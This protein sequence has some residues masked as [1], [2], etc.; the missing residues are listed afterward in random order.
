MA[1]TALV[2]MTMPRL[3]QRRAAF[4]D[5]EGRRAMRSAVSGLIV[6]CNPILL[7]LAASAA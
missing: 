1:M 6:R 5:N 3:L 2:P 4:V 7:P